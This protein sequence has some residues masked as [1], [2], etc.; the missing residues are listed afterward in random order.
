MIFDSEDLYQPGIFNEWG[1]DSNP[2]E[3][4]SKMPGFAVF[5][6]AMTDPRLMPEILGGPAAF[7]NVWSGGE[8]GKGYITMAAEG[9]YI[10]QLGLYSVTG[11]LRNAIGGVATTVGFLQRSAAVLT[12]VFETRIDQVATALNVVSGI[13]DSQAFNA[14]I[15]AIGVIPIVGWIIKILVEVAKI[16]TSIVDIVAQKNRDEAEEALARV[17]TLPMPQWS[18]QADGHLAKLCQISASTYN[19]QWLVMPRYPAYSPDDFTGT[20]IDADDNNRWDGW[21]VHPA[22]FTAPETGSEAP[23]GLGFVPGTRNIHATMQLLLGG[24]KNITDLGTFYPVASMTAANLWEQMLKGDHPSTMCVDT[25]MAMGAWEAYIHAAL[26]FAFPTEFGGSGILARGWSM[27]PSANY[28]ASSH[29]CVSGMEDAYGCS[30]GDVTFA[31]DVNIPGTGHTDGFIAYLNTLFDFERKNSNGDWSL[32]NIDTARSRPVRA[33][34]ELRDAQVS[35][36]ES[37]DCMYLTDMETP[38]GRAQY[39]ALG[40]DAPNRRGPLWGQWAN[41]VQKV[42]ESGSWV[43]VN[44]ADVPPHTDD[45]GAEGSLGRNRVRDSIENMVA[46]KYSMG[47][48]EF[49]ATKHQWMLSA[50]ANALPDTPVPPPAPTAPAVIESTAWV[51]MTRVGGSAAGGIR[52]SAAGLAMAAGVAMLL[53]KGRK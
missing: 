14:A 21:I 52:T 4:E 20:P 47:A 42:F 35:V 51:D 8:P 45:A 5:N 2:F 29:T 19:L 38:Q 53:L 27:S 10:S 41:N 37:M 23:P 40:V 44:W 25:D 24:A 43:N 1:R 33:L 34:Q 12:G 36:I 9:R 11:A 32:G 28:G 26:D 31:R 49:F 39:A 30:G 50:P 6:S 3:W 15:N 13:L 22:M 7:D 17:A 48:D 46:S 16:I 18:A